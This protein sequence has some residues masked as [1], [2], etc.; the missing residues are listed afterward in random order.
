MPLQ[1]TMCRLC[2]LSR[3]EFRRTVDRLTTEYRAELEVVE[4]ECMAACDDVPA[5][6]IECDYYPQVSPSD[7][8]SLLRK[9]LSAIA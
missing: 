2:S 8:V 4:L 6:M 1:L 7:L 9:E 3:P 5:V